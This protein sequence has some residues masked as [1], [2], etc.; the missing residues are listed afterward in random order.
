MTT[1][2]NTTLGMFRES[3]NSFVGELKQDF[4]VWQT[5]RVS[6]N[7]SFAKA[8]ECHLGVKPGQGPNWKSYFE[9]YLIHKALRFWPE[10]EVWGIKWKESESGDLLCNF[11]IVFDGYQEGPYRDE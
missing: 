3:F 9:T 10:G 8:Y 4:K 5:S 2:V 11:S 1:A 6:D 7:Y